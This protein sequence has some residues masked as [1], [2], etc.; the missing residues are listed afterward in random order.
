MKN[1]YGVLIGIFL[2]ATVLCIFGQGMAYFLSEYFVPISPVYYLTGMTI[3]G[4]FLYLVAGFL[5]FR[6]FK[7]QEFASNNRPFYLLIL[8]TVGPIAS[9][10]SFFVTVMWWG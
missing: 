5:L 3:L 1:F 10:W 9:I 2:L 6:L 7:K 8:F 4:I